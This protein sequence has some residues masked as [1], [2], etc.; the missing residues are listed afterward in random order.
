MLQ[1]SGEEQLVPYV[2][3]GKY[4]DA[5]VT[6][7]PQFTTI[8][9]D[10]DKLAAF[11]AWLGPY[12]FFRPLALPP[13][14]PKERVE[15]LRTALRKTMQDSAFLADAKKSQLDVEYTSGEVIE[16]NLKEILALPP[17]A[18]QMLASIIGLGKEKN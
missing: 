4:D 1:A 8:I 10:K 16:K 6:N 3:Q 15:I 13:N 18:E 17:K 7:L 14:T 9:K 11:K 2:I 5:L 12:E